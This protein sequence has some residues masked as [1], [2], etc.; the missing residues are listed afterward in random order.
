VGA[1]A[2][3]SLDNLVPIYGFKLVLVFA[4]AATM[5]SAVFAFLL[6]RHESAQ[7]SVLEAD[8]SAA[9]AVGD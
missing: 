4:S 7:R 3:P 1:L 5:L 8:M 2:P 9:R 6:P